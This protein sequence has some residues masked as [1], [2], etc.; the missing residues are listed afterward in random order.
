MR[1]ELVDSWENLL[2]QAR[3]PPV[4]RD[5][6]APF[7]RQAIIACERDI[8]E[9]LG[10][11]SIPSPLPARGTAMASWLLRDGTGPIHN[12]HRFGDLGA[13]LRET[14]MRLDASVPL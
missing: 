11:L 1:R 4:M 8:Q 13:T 3:R 9:L 10:A 12:R 5:P 6:R 14:I 2:V 7:N